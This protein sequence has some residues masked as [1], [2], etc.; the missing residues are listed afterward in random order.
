M[1]CVNHQENSSA[2]D[3]ASLAPPTGP[4]GPQSLSLMGS[5]PSLNSNLNLASIASAQP[6][7]ESFDPL[8]AL[9]A[10]PSYRIPA[11]NQ[12]SQNMAQLGEYSC[13]LHTYWENINY[14]VS[15]R[16]GSHSSS[17]SNLDPLAALMAPPSANRYSAVS[18]PNPNNR[19]FGQLA[20]QSS[21]GSSG[22]G[23]FMD[24]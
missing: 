1:S 2:P 15:F 11:A 24:Y 13:M 7:Q 14:F 8:A 10:P 9:I 16:S 5:N 3:P 19:S 22:K 21:A 23:G 18:Y 6:P 4:I 12:S 20:P 17:N